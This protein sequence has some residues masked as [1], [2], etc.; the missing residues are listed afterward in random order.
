MCE[1]VSK[2]SSNLKNY[3]APGPR[4]PVLKFLDPPLLY[5][6][7]CKLCV[8]W[9]VVNTKFTSSQ[10]VTHPVKYDMRYERQLC[11]CY[12]YATPTLR[13]NWL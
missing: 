12:A 9:V 4:P 11:V 3:T 5:V 1:G 8:Y 2:Q 7:N 13:N 6:S 10:I